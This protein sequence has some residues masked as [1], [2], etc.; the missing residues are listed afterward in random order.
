[1]KANDKDASF[2]FSTEGKADQVL[3][4]ATTHYARI[5]R[6]SS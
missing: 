2:A 4:G 6:A 1:M 3:L 5:S